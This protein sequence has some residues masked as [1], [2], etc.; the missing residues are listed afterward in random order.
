MNATFQ[1]SYFLTALVLFGLLA[2]FAG[3]G[4]ATDTGK[5]AMAQFEEG[6]RK[7]TIVIR[8]KGQLA[9]AEKSRASLKTMADE[10]SINSEKE[11][12]KIKQLEEARNE[13]IKDFEKLA[14]IA[15]NA[16]LPEEINATAEDKTKNIPIGT[17]TF[18]GA[19]VYRELKKGRDQLKE[20]KA[21]IERSRKVSDFYAKRAELIHSQMS[22]VDDNIATMKNKIADYEMYQKLLGANATFKT[23]GIPEGKI[24]EL[25]KTDGIMAEL[26]EAVLDA[27]ARL[28]ISDGE[29]AGGDITTEI[30]RTSS[31]TFSIDDL[32]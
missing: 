2:T 31:S 6:L 5:G 28:K 12:G 7:G 29:I 27:E 4:V 30:N 1:F 21:H 26:R 24:D 20:A 11:L 25:V 15:Q 17:K 14:G 32:L 3:C 8:A 23:L 10:F 13:V 18:T 19:E 22:R 16:G 9:D